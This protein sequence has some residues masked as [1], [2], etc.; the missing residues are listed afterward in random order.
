MAKLKRQGSLNAIEFENSGLNK[1]N[2]MASEKSSRRHRRDKVGN[3]K[4][5]ET[6]N[7]IKFDDK[8][9]NCNLSCINKK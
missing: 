1:N 6:K 9:E 3:D 8:K 5:S 2:G 7:L 4:D